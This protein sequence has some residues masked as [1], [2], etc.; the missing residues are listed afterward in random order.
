MCY[1]NAIKF[2]SEEDCSLYK[3]LELAK[4]SNYGIDKLNSEVLASLLL[5]SV[6]KDEV[7]NLNFSEVFKNLDDLEDTN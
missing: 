5:W 2:L 1:A 7:D 6:C 4:I 3:S